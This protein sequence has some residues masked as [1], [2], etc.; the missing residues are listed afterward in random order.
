[1][2]VEAY[3]VNP[4]EVNVRAIRESLGMTQ[5]VFASTF[6]LAIG[7]IRNW[8]QRRSEPDASMRS[9]IAVIKNNPHAVI[10]ALEKERAGRECRRAAH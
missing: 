8:E 6:G 10:A 1:M 5:A 4:G 7:S 2:I 3:D 9:Y